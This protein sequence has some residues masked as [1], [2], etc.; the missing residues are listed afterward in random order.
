MF[1]YSFVKVLPCFVSQTSFFKLSNVQ[2][3]LSSQFR[4]ETLKCYYRITALYNVVLNFPSNHH[5]KTLKTAMCSENCPFAPTIRFAQYLLSSLLKRK[6]GVIT[7]PERMKVES[8]FV[9]TVVQP[10]DDAAT[11]IRVKFSLHYHQL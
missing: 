6:F 5:Q 11:D 9:S 3:E 10:S 1:V 4:Y 2:I 7:I 8:S